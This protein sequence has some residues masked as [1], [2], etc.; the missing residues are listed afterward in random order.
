MRAQWLIAALLW[1]TAGFVHAQVTT[2]TFYGIVNDPAG[3]VVPGA[4]V[5]LTHEATGTATAKTTDAAG[6]FAFDFLRVGGFALR[7]EAS[8]FK[9][10]TSRGIELAASQKVRRSFVLEIGAVT[11]S[12]EVKGET[13]LLNTVAAEQRESL[14]RREIAELPMSQ[15][16]FQ[17]ILSIGTGITT[18]ADGGVRMNGLGR[19]GLKVTVDGTDASSNPENPGT[20]LKNNFNYI[21][22]MSIEAIQEVQTT[23]GVTAAEYGQQ[24]SG[25]VNLIAKSGTNQWHGTLFENFKAENLNASDRL[26]RRKPPFTF[27]QFGGSVGGPIQQNKVFIFGTYEG[28]RESSFATLQG[29]VPTLKLRDEAIRAVPAY[30]IFLDTLYLPNQP[31]APTAD[32][33]RFLG[34]AAE[35]RRD[36]HAVVKG[37]IRVGNSGILAVTYTRGRPYRL[38]PVG[39]TQIGNTQ[40]F[41]G[42]QERGTITHI[43]GGAQW[44]SE[45]RFGYNFNDSERVDGWWLLGL[46]PETPEDTPGGR[47]TPS[48]RVEGLFG[49]GGGS[50]F[51]NNFGPVWSMEEKFARHVGSH[52]FKFGGIYNRRVNGRFDIENNLIRYANK[53]DFLANIPNRIQATFGNNRF[54]ASSYELGV[55]AQDDWRVRRNLVLN[56]GIRYDFFS[57]FV[58]RASDPTAPAGLFNPDGLLDGQFRFGPFRDPSN[59]IEN[60]ARVNLGPRFGFS[61]SPGA[62]G[63]NVIRGG[64]GIM[65]GPQPWDDYDR[66]VSTSPRLPRR[67]IYNRSEALAQGLRFPTYND[68]LRPRVESGATL[69]IANAFDP[70]IQNPYSIQF[71]LGAQR[72]LTSNLM[73]ESAF[74]GT[75]GIKFRLT[76]AFNWPD[77]VTDIR[78]NPLLGE[79]SYICAC[80]DTIY[81]S[82][83]TSLRKRYSQS[84]SF[85]GHYTWGKALSVT[86]GDTGAN[87]SGDTSNSIQNFFDIRSNRGPS[88]GDITHRFVGD[89]VY[90]LPKLANLSNA[91]ARQALGGWQ[92][93]GILSAQTGEPANVSQSGLETRAD[94]VGGNP[95]NPNRDRD[96]IYLNTA[97]FRMVPLGRGGNPIRP[98]NL[99]NGAIRRTGRWTL[100]LSLGK[101]FRVSE[102]IGLQVRADLFNAPNHTGYSTFTGSINSANFGRFTGFYAAREMQLNA[103]LSW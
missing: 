37:D 15:R 64:V 96:G 81:T 3:A 6:E 40:D 94:Y 31:H 99:G 76:R 100:D 87:F 29:D 32:T 75:R 45:T 20:S 16:S 34:A 49:D 92:V 47:R 5:T 55:F 23:K 101:N 86:G 2:A 80:Q 51:I 13:P 72:I 41:R 66:A 88:A 70:H 18:S 50:E 7:I 78:P 21:H 97:A 17:N 38:T 39:R 48:F 84:L 93:S 14:G 98:G 77:R 56:L 65:F 61:Y 8:G 19:S 33:G 26:L 30:K 10:Y 90:E 58:A 57:R 67:V 52:S 91:L 83:Q 71:Y 69:Q 27:N 63:R 68:D 82:W 74:V 59:P 89:W 79:G 36:N 95:I 9:T 25:N 12:V 73:V 62:G 28:Y 1:I 60:D 11:E 42:W 53:A 85:A 43:M 35:T 54:S 46:R 102:K 103:R 44:S 22:V 24:M 4:A